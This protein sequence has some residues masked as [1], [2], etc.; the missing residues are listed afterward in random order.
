MARGLIPRADN[1]KTHQEQHEWN[2]IKA[3]KG[4]IA[5]E[6]QKKKEKREEPTDLQVLN[7][8]TIKIKCR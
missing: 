3:E 8:V 4:R 1:L 5:V 6:E 7:T 2:M